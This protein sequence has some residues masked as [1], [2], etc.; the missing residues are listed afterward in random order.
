MMKYKD[1][2]GKAEFDDEAG[3]LHGEVVNVRDVI[4]FQATNV[5]DLQRE[6]EASVD[7]YLEFCAELGEEPDKP[8]S[9]KFMTRVSPD[10]HR[11]AV[12]AAKLSGDSLNIWINKA[13]TNYVC[14]SNLKNVYSSKDELFTGKSQL[15][16]CMHSAAGA[17]INEQR[18]IFYFLDLIEEFFACHHDI[19]VEDDELKSMLKEA[20]RATEP[21]IEFTKRHVHE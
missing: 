19:D 4:T 15:S 5:D 7:D 20:R 2:V 8:F 6:F 21:L 9:G 16:K 18:R 17:R 3:I 14:N 1:Y 10:L 12:I 13:I 11:E